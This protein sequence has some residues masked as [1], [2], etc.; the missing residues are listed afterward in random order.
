MSG[1]YEDLSVKGDD[2]EIVAGLKDNKI[3]G[4]WRPVVAFGNPKAL[5]EQAEGLLKVS[6]DIYYCDYLCDGVAS[7]FGLHLLKLGYKARPY[8]TQV[9]DLTKS[10]EE[11]HVD[12]RKSYKSLVNKYPVYNCTVKPVKELHQKMRGIV[13]TEKTWELQDRMITDRKAFALASGEIGR[14]TMKTTAGTIVY[15]SPVWAYYACGISDADTNSH[16][17][18]WSSILR[19]KELGV[20]YFEMGEQTYGDDKLA[21]ISNFKRGFGGRT[22]TRLI[23]T[24]E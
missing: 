12:L 2:F 22:I 15:Y 14:Q 6:D 7:E 21:N 10:V 5:K 4:F 3:S 1:P 11:L 24:K 9:I 19:A 13:R 18:I 23:L 17:V 16:H 20:K 8:Y